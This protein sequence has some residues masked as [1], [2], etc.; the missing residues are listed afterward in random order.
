MRAASEAGGSEHVGELLP[1]YA[2]TITLRCDSSVVA[3]IL[4]ST[5]SRAGYCILFSALFGPGKGRGVAFTRTH[6]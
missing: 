1:V 5:T 4:V 3:Q 6:F 2:D